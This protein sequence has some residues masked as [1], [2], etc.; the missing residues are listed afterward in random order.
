MRETKIALSMSVLILII[1]KYG[2]LDG[3]SFEFNKVS[4]EVRKFAYFVASK[5]PRLSVTV[6]SVF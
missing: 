1:I 3:G 2:I 4:I 6:L 5:L